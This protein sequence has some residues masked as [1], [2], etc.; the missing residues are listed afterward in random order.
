MVKPDVKVNYYA[1]LELGSDASVDE[2]KK[3]YRKLALKWHPDRN[4][5][6]EEE[7][8]PKFQAI[9][10]AHEVLG[11]ATIKAKYDA[12]RRRANL[13]GPAPAAASARPAASGQRGN[14]Y[15][16]TSNFAPPPRR[17]ADPTGWT[18]PPRTGNTSGSG[19]DRFANFPGPSP[20]GR[21]TDANKSTASEAWG[22]FG[23]PK[24]QNSQQQ[25]GP[26]PVPPR[27]KAE[28][29]R[30][31]GPNHR[32]GFA[33]PTNPAYANFTSAYATTA[34]SANPASGQRPN[35]QRQNTNNTP[36]RPG[37]DPNT[38]GSD[39]R[40]TA[41]PSSYANLHNHQ[42]PG[43]PSFAQDR[44][45]MPPPPPPT[46]SHP[47]A[48]ADTT[49]S[50]G[51]RRPA[52]TGV[53]RT[54]STYAHSGGEKTYFSSD[55]LKR[56]QSTRDT[57]KLPRQGPTR[58]RSASP[59]KAPS[60]PHSRTTTF[61]LPTDSEDSSSESDSS[62]A[63]S[64]TAQKG[65]SSDGLRPKKVPTSRMNGANFRDNG[66][67]SSP[68]NRRPSQP[69]QPGQ[70][71]RKSS[72]SGGADQPTSNNMYE[73]TSSTSDD[74]SFSASD[75]CAS[76]TGHWHSFYPFGPKKPAPDSRR[77]TVPS[78]AIPSSI[79]Y[80]KSGKQDT[81]RSAFQQDDPGYV[82][83]PPLIDVTTPGSSSPS[84]DFFSL[85]TPTKVRKSHVE[86][87]H[88]LQS[89]FREFIPYSARSHARND[90]HNKYSVDADLKNSF[91]MPSGFD[92]YQS[93]QNRSTDEI[94]T[95]F[96]PTGDAPVFTGAPA[97]KSQPFPRRSSPPKRGRETLS[98]RQSRVPLNTHVNSDRPQSP[99]TPISAANSP[100]FGNA[101]SQQSTATA[102]ERVF[103]PEHW[104]DINLGLDP[105][106]RASEG[107]RVQTGC[108]PH[109]VTVN[110]TS[111]TSEEPERRVR[112]PAAS[113]DAMDI[114]STPP[115]QTAQENSF[116]TPMSQWRHSQ[117]AAQRLHHAKRSSD[118]RSSAAKVTLEEH[119]KGSTGN[120][121]SLNPLSETLNGSSGVGLGD[122][123]SLN[124]AVPFTSK[125]SV[126]H[127]SRMFSTDPAPSVLPKPPREPDLPTKLSRSSWKKYTGEMADYLS[128]WHV[129]QR[130]LAEHTRETLERQRKLVSQ[131]TT[132]LE[133]RGETSTDGG[134][135][136]YIYRCKE[137]E[138]H[139]AL[140]D[141]ALSEHIAS[142]ETF[143]KI[144]ERVREL[145]E[146]GTLH[147]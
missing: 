82:E 8:N 27:Q 85:R 78:W 81:T 43:K 63:T 40:P 51:S 110:D 42:Y 64:S 1:A 2:V 56:S 128:A 147:D 23:N 3:Q 48:F 75:N 46:A 123:S 145:A 133:A 89:A 38:P 143:S 95:A 12:D 121:P 114:D 5:G 130:Q 41:G 137:E 135:G 115:S 37:F 60:Q 80:Q 134:L 127:P 144:K 136:A 13:S 141:T 86:D 129:F 113:A 93:T 59:A 77:G 11:D 61:G 10:A 35:A 66:T 92:S 112:P 124:S 76:S 70:Q 142:M 125:A 15:A 20:T 53:N 7:C 146:A 101:R 55:E 49:S 17:T 29:Y 14:P 73:N 132:G 91:T 32:P 99:V 33:F 34:S 19:A 139:A 96:S 106:R 44:E 26:P 84:S 94:D 131:G 52:F 30:A 21:Q 98:A 120:L 71:S 111:D 67:N 24:K 88:L 116:T 74:P 47:S 25:R 83:D 50:P 122:L 4:P 69:G 104:A 119:R 65:Q 126:A 79:R 90:Y 140:A 103:S 9:S 31:A 97:G 118:M 87:M 109:P 22:F 117:D 62:S 102:P 36:R 39:E 138:R 100:M 58:H 45:H 6:K 105:S 18:R 57:S 72:V 108:V 28:D 107:G 54:T 68:H 16:A